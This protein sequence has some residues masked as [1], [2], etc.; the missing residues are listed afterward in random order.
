MEASILLD[1]KFTVKGLSALHLRQG[2]RTHCHQE[3]GCG[4]C[5]TYWGGSCHLS[6]Q[7]HHRNYEWGRV[8]LKSLVAETILGEGTQLWQLSSRSLMFCFVL[9][10]YFL[11]L[12]ILFIFSHFLKLLFKYSCLHFPSNTSSQPRHL[13]FPPLVLPPFHLVH[14]S[15]IHVPGNPSP[16]SPHYPFP[17]LSVFKNSHLKHL[18]F[19]KQKS[20]GN[21]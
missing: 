12:N 3:P 19:F 4:N 14:V 13:H 6:N 15:F 20:W 11:Y 9:F 21:L 2:C 1:K 5:R 16:F 17:P 8:W 7:G 10:C 18:F